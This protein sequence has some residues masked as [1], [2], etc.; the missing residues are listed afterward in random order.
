MPIKLPKS[1]TKSPSE[2]KKFEVFAKKGKNQKHDKS[3]GIKRYK[4]KDFNLLILLK[5]I[6]FNPIII[7]RHRAIKICKRKD[8]VKKR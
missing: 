6:I 7:K 5:S 4:Y 8:N 1:G 2:P 3:R